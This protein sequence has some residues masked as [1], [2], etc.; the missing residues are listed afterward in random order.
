MLVEKPAGRDL[1]EVQAVAAAA[2][3][4]G[5]IVKVG[6]NHRFHPAFSK[7][8]EIVDAGAL[9]PLMFIRGALRP[10]RPRSA[11][12]RNGARSRE[13]PAAAS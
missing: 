2:A 10:R 9:G 1:A 13:S 7:A 5:R 4:H 8:R 11:T 3:K 12:K 6:F